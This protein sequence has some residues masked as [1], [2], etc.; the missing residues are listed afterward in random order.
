MATIQRFEDFECWKSGRELKKIIYR[1]TKT[2]PFSTD[3]SLI[4]QIRRA[5]QSITS[6]ASLRLHRLQISN[7]APEA[8]T[9][10]SEP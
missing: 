10:N 9:L 4:D 3:F 1:F 5:A 8:K 6:N 2:K 7:H